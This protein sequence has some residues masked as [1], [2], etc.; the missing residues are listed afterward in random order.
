MRKKQREDK[1]LDVDASMQ[2]N[3]VFKDP[4]NLRINGTFEGGLDT[5]GTLVIGE[6]AT[7]KASITGEDVTIAG[8]VTGDI[9]ASKSLRLVPPARVMGNI[10]SP[11]LSI[12][13]G[14]IFEG[15]CLMSKEKSTKSIDK[16]MLSVNEV[17]DYLEVD[18]ALI[19]NWAREGKLPGTKDKD[20]WRF[21]RNRLD[22]W[23]ANEKI[24]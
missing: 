21:D 22:E 17:A 7:V 4:V 10:K 20:N 15:K 8:S 1:I 14:S 13:E 11:I 16:K 23:I 19:L 5:K 24:R 18:T 12:T 3:M 2:G 9:N 6:N